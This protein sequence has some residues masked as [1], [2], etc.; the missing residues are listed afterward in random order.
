ML[1]LSF[2]GISEQMTGHLKT[3]RQMRDMAYEQQRQQQS[4]YHNV[5]QAMAHP[6]PGMMQMQGQPQP[7]QPREMRWVGVDPAQMIRRGPPQ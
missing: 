6:P 4:Q 5:A 7:Q 2:E 3:R 1:K